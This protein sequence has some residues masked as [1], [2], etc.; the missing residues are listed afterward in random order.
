MIRERGRGI[1]AAILV[2]RDVVVAIVIAVIA[3]HFL[4]MKNLL[5]L[6]LG[7]YDPDGVIT[8]G[9]G[10]CVANRERGG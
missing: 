9:Y 7:Q 10:K 8:F 3:V 1:N 2:E 6:L 4:K 5:V